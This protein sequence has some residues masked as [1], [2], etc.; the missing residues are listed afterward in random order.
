MQS[1]TKSYSYCKRLLDAAIAHHLVIGEQ[2]KWAVLCENG[3]LDEYPY[4]QVITHLTENDSDRKFLISR[5]M[6]QSI[7]L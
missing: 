7:T 1:D 4:Q 3:V 2:N 5:L 6:T